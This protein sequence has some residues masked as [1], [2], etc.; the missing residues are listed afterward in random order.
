MIGQC[1]VEWS[2]QVVLGIWSC[3]IVSSG[4]DTEVRPPAGSRGAAEE[5]EKARSAK[6]RG[7]LGAKRERQWDLLVAGNSMRNNTSSF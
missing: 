5:R 1:K 2:W 3:L 7:D 6:G 4:P